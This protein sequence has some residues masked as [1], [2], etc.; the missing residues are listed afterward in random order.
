MEVKKGDDIFFE[1]CDKPLKMGGGIVKSVQK[2]CPFVDVLCKGEGMDYRT[3]VDK[4][5]RIYGNVFN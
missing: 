5:K 1:I 3:T 2:G 4:I